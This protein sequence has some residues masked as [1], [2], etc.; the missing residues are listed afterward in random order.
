MVQQPIIGNRYRIKGL[1][2]DMNGKQIRVTHVDG[3]YVYG[4][5]ELEQGKWFNC[6][7]YKNELEEL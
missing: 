2:L 4:D 7:V 5:V 6:E 1:S 3:F